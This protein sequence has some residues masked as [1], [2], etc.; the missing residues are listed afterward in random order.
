MAFGKKLKIAVLK[1]GQERKKE[2]EKQKERARETW[3]IFG[4]CVRCVRTR[5]TKIKREKMKKKGKRKEEV[6]EVA[7][8]DRW[9]SAPRCIDWPF[10]PGKECRRNQYVVSETR[11]AAA[12]NTYT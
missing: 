12:T 4:L 3:Y 2:K 7:D 8:S 10:S 11:M 6:C 1:E 9:V 5:M